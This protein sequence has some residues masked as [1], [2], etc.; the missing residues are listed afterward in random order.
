[1]KYFL[2]SFFVFRSF[3]NLAQGRCH[4][5]WIALLLFFLLWNDT[6]FSQIKTIGIPFIRNYSRKEYNAGTQN[7]AIA[8]DNR[9]VIYFGNNNG[10]M[11]YDGNTWNIFGIPNHSII[12]S[13]LCDTNGTIYA[14]AFNE[15]GYLYPDRNGQ[16]QYHSLSSKLTGKYKLFD[17]LWRI[18]KLEDG[19]LFHS[20]YAAFFVKDTSVKILKFNDSFGYSGVWNNT[21]YIQRLGKGL[22]AINLQGKDSL[23]TNGEFFKDK[24]ITLLLPWKNTILAGTSDQGIFVL[25]NNKFRAWN[26]PV[27]S[28]LKENQIFTGIRLTN[29]SYA[30]GTVQ[31]GLIIFDAE[32]NLIQH[33]SKLKGL[34]NNTILSLFQDR[35]NN[36]WLGLDNGIDFVKLNSPLTY[37]SPSKE[38]G[39]GYCSVLYNGLLY[40]GTNQGLYYADWEKLTHKNFEYPEFARI[41]NTSGQ[42]WS[43]Q[44]LGSK[45][46]CGHNNGFYEITGNRAK[47]FANWPGGWI[48]VNMP[49]KPEFLIGGTYRGLVLL[50]KQ[51]QGNPPRLVKPVAGFNESCREIEVDEQNTFWVGHG[52]KGIYRLRLNDK[53][54][55][56]IWQ[57]C[58][59]SENGLPSDYTNSLFRLNNEILVS[60]VD[61]IFVFNEKMN[62][63]V[64]S[65]KYNV[66]FGTHK[67]DRI[68]Q[69]PNRDIWYFQDNQLVVLRQSYNGNYAPESLPFAELKENF[70]VPYEHINFIDYRN[71]IISTQDGFLH[72]DPVLVQPVKSDLTVLIRQIA[73]AEGNII[74]GGNFRNEKGMSTVSRPYFQIKYLPYTFNDLKFEYSA[75]T[76][77]NI[78]NVE[79]AYYLEGFDKN[80]SEWSP[81]KSKEYPNLK[82]GSY[83][84]HVKAKTQ[85][86]PQTEPVTFEF[87]IN[88]PWYRS[89]FALIVYV[90]IILLL[91]YSIRGM[92]KKRIEKEKEILKKKQQEVLERTQQ[93]FENE[94]LQAEQEIMNLRNE[95]LQVEVERN[96]SE[97]ESRTKELAAVAMQITYK[98]EL[99]NQLKNRLTKV[100]QKITHDDSRKQILEM[101]RKLEEEHLHED[102]WHL[103]EQHFDQVHENFL[104][105]VKE[106]CPGLTPKDLKMC[107]YLRMNLS[108]KEIAPL[109]NISIRGVEISRYRLRKK[110]NLDRDDN[111]IEYLMKI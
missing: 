64:P 68:Y 58:Y 50:H 107:A 92:L 40:L 60:S 10:I 86:D 12:R 36:L 82:E 47:L 18:Y 69:D 9:G 30:I 48:C 17:E 52:Y 103:F 33:I 108:S 99:L 97:L 6:A 70:V 73:S 106:T 45:L 38:I 8:Q 28:F 102:D 109:L 78:E 16:L 39:A 27:N 61:G 37:M 2:N 32:G 104:K 77:D 43:L 85:I 81:S 98:N 87:V 71:I 21:L 66:L 5:L 42:V 94:K 110:L 74:F 57:A 29:G 80:W 88:P 95:K 76:F 51:S 56:V 55:S 49:S 53:L 65:E 91:G 111:L 7:W 22:Y 93:E 75:T 34:Q 20:F 96:K 31:S 63:F 3:N 24:S 4:R 44:V 23:V 25:E 100:T 67:I 19:V 46:I 90:L 1:M 54:D 59:D 11:E 14:G 15:F 84:F 79:Y 35:H 41:P 89:A 13:L 101:I 83:I 105:H 26:N 62:R 72:F